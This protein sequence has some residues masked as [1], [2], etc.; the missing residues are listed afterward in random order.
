[1]VQALQQAMNRQQGPKLKV[2]V[3]VNKISISWYLYFILPNK[4]E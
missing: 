3:L 4:T 2:A 1:V